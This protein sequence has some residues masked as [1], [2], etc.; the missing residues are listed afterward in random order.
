M[1]ADFLNQTD[2]KTY[3]EIRDLVTGIVKAN[4]LESMPVVCSSC[5]K[6]YKINLDFNQSNFFV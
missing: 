1:I 6:E 3:E 2:R 4:A 5:E